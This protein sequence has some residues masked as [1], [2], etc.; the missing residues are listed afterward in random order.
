MNLILSFLMDVGSQTFF[1]YLFL[2]FS[3]VMVMVFSSASMFTSFSSIPGISD[4]IVRWFSS[5]NTSNSGCLSFFKLG[6]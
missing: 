5:S 1:R 6:I 2:A 4:K 3:A